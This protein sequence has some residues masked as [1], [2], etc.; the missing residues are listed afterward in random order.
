MTALFTVRDEPP[1]VTVTDTFGDVVH[2]V[3]WNWTQVVAKPL[4]LG[5]AAH[6]AW[7]LVPS[8]WPK[9]KNH[10]KAVQMSSGTT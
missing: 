9:S 1:A 5:R 4:R 3:V 10:F 6:R 2:G 8:H 7:R